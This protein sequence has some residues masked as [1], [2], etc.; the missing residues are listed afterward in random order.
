MEDAMIKEDL[1]H[2]ETQIGELRATQSNGLMNAVAGF[3]SH[4][5]TEDGSLNEHCNLRVAWRR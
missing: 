3:P 5:V 4:C 1:L 2:I